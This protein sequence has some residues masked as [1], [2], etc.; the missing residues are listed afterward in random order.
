MKHSD[1]SDSSDLDSVH[2]L[3]VTSNTEKHNLTKTANSSGGTPQASYADIA[4]MVSIN[5]T[6]S[7]LNDTHMVPNVLNS[8]NWPS[9]T[10]TKAPSE[11]DKL[12]HDS[13]PSLDEIQHSERRMRQNNFSHSNHVTS[14]LNLSFDKPP[15]PV[16]MKSK[17]DNKKAE[18]REEA[19]NK[20]IQVFKYVQDIEKMQQS[21]TQVIFFLLP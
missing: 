16:M 5:M 19:I 18:A 21:L 15:S 9:V 8:T 12:T 6:N 7:I 4:R 17:I 13:Y 2:S 14:A 1:K 10:T 3:P 20:N 11:P